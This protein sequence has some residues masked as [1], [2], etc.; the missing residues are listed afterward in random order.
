MIADISQSTLCTQYSDD[1]KAQIRIHVRRG[2]WWSRALISGP[3]G[4][5]ERIPT[6]MDW[7]IW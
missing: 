2:H 1:E 7:S 3:P 6:C 5:G 4:E